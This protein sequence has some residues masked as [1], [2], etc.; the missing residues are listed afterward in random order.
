MSIYLFVLIC[1]FVSFYQIACNNFLK[2]CM[3]S[4]SDM[5]G[6]AE[7]FKKYAACLKNKGLSGTP[8]GPSELVMDAND[9]GEPGYSG[10]VTTRDV[11][12]C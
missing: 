11:N 5:L 4:A 7:C 3:S 1:L 10:W 6:K 8:S 2:K 9:D 12:C